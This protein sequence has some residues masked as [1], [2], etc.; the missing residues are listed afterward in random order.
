M[1]KYT[2]QKSGSHIHWTGKKVLGLHTGSIDLQEGF[3]GLE[4]DNILSGSII[5]DMSTII[6]TDMDDL[7]EKN[8]F[9]QH[10]LHEDFFDVERYKQARLVI[11][12]SSFLSDRL[13]EVKANVTIKDITHPVTFETTIEIFTDYLLATGELSID[14]TLYNIR[15]GSGKFLENLGDKLIYDHFV[16][17]FKLIGRRHSV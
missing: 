17:Q 4:Q 14:R 8:Q 13:Y 9:F 11:T 6:I 15:Y 3:V 16:L 10:L 12:G 2:I 1:A 5:I 7:P